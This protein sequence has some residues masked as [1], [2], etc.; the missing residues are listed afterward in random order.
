M[1]ITL[2]HGTYA[3]NAKWTQDSSTFVKEIKKKFPRVKIDKFLWTSLNSVEARHRASNTLA[4]KLINDG[5]KNHF[6]IGHSHGGNICLHTLRNKDVKVKGIVTINTPFFYVMKRDLRWIL[7]WMI[8][9]LITYSILGILFLLSKN[10]DNSPLLEDLFPL[11]KTTILIAIGIFS[12]LS[13]AIYGLIKSKLI[14]NWILNVHNERSQELVKKINPVLEF[15]APMLCINTGEDE[16]FNWLQL[17]DN[18]ANIFPLLLSKW[19][20]RLALIGLAIGLFIIELPSIENLDFILIIEAAFLS[21]VALPIVASLAYAALI[22]I[23]FIMAYFLRGL[24]QGNFKFTF[25]HLFSRVIVSIIPINYKNLVFWQITPSRKK[26]FLL[27]HGAFF[28]DHDAISKTLDWIDKTNR[29]KIDRR[30][31]F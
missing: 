2:I 24:P 17:T 21:L 1:K 8:I 19:F 23:S 4:K 28:E 10:M 11:T 29:K 5:E 13:L 14:T 6:I 12:L 3:R 15:E 18:L 20:G 25:I 16:A 31:H 26:E 27:S 7:R 9:G 30:K 22:L